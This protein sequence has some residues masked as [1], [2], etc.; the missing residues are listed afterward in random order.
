MSRIS[1]HERLPVQEKTT[2]ADEG[3]ARDDAT[4]PG[5]L[6]RTQGRFQKRRDKQNANHSNERKRQMTFS[7]N[8]N[9][10]GTWNRT[11]LQY[12]TLAAGAALAAGAVLGLGRWESGDS[13]S[14]ASPKPSA[15]VSLSTTEQ[16]PRMT[17]YIVGSEEEA[18]RVRELDMQAASYRSE[19]GVPEPSV[20]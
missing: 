19:A 10:A 8:P 11:K 15:P 5:F 9:N 17:V 16:T 14:V 4:P 2:R 7:I 18:A 6:G 12:V 1:P 13:S 20:G 3:D